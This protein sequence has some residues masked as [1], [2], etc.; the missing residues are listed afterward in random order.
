MKR[1]RGR[2]KRRKNDNDEDEEK[3]PMPSIASLVT[4]PDLPGRVSCLSCIVNELKLLWTG[5]AEDLPD[6]EVWSTSS[7]LKLYAAEHPSF[8]LARLAALSVQNTLCAV[9]LSKLEESYELALDQSSSDGDFTTELLVAIE[10]SNAVS[11]LAII[12]FVFDRCSSIDT[13]VRHASCQALLKKRKMVRRFIQFCRDDVVTETSK[14]GQRLLWCLVYVPHGREAIAGYG[15]GEALITSFLAWLKRVREAQSISQEHERDFD[16]HSNEVANRQKE[17]TMCK[18]NNEAARIQAMRGLRQAKIDFENT[19]E[20]LQS[21]LGRLE[22][23]EVH[24]NVSKESLA[25]VAK[26]QAQLEKHMLMLLA[27]LGLITAGPAY[28]MQAIMHRY[29]VVDCVVDMI[30]RC[31]VDT[32]KAGYSEMRKQALLTV[33]NFANRFPPIQNTLRNKG[34]LPIILNELN[35]PQPSNDS[36]YTVMVSNVLYKCIDGNPESGE[37]VCNLGILG[38]LCRMLHSLYHEIVHGDSEEDEDKRDD[39]DDDGKGETK[40]ENESKTDSGAE[41]KEIKL[42]KESAE[43]KAARLS[44]SEA[45]LRVLAECSRSSETRREE[46]LGENVI[47]PLL[48]LAATPNVP[49]IVYVSLKCLGNL[50]AGHKPTQDTIVTG[51][52]SGV[53]N[54]LSV[55]CSI[56]DQ[57]RAEVR[58]V[59]ETREAKDLAEPNTEDERSL[60]ENIAFEAQRCLRLVVERNDRSR[61]RAMDGVVL[62]SCCELLENRSSDAMRRDACKILSAVLGNDDRVDDANDNGNVSSPS[63]KIQKMGPAAQGTSNQDQNRHCLYDTGLPNRVCQDLLFD[64]NVFPHLIRCVAVPNRPAIEDQHEEDEESDDNE[65]DDEQ[66]E[67]DNNLTDIAPLDVAEQ[68][69]E[70]IIETCEEENQLLQKEEVADTALSTIVRENPMDVLC[71]M[72]AAAAKTVGRLVKSHTGGKDYACRIQH[73]PVSLLRLIDFAEPMQTTRV[74]ILSKRSQAGAGDA[75]VAYARRLGARWLFPEGTYPGVRIE[76]ALALAWCIQGT[77]LLGKQQALRANALQKLIMLNGAATLPERVAAS[78]ALEHL[79]HNSALAREDFRR[80]GGLLP[81]IAMLMGQPE[82]ITNAVSLITCIVINNAKNKSELARLGGVPALVRLLTHAKVEHA[83]QFS[84]VLL[85]KHIIMHPEDA[86]ILMDTYGGRALPKLVSLLHS[87]KSTLTLL[88]SC[89][90]I[91]LCSRDSERLQILLLKLGTI[92]LLV[93]MITPPLKIDDKTALF[94]LA[95]VTNCA[96]NMA[97]RKRLK[98][99]GILRAMEALGAWEGQG[100][101]VEHL[102]RAAST[103]L[104]ACTE[105]FIFDDGS[106]EFTQGLIVSDVTAGIWKPWPY[107][108][109]VQQ[110]AAKV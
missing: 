71:A 60:S 77:E 105:P 25:S 15:G 14:F 11:R 63:P 86:D 101:D 33:G 42:E 9:L 54:G 10:A 67:N 87:A 65:S 90:I 32:D 75:S 29:G 88:L 16:H 30:N 59:I 39:D 38:G 22:A 20:V 83:L 45:S 109:K 55:L 62:T 74:A 97:C 89:Q 80:L 53:G 98:R 24:Y 41:G 2:R 57:V 72:R 108:D 92:E 5:N 4:T 37:A 1:R 18:E 106:A 47:L 58:D 99:C 6:D 68:Q 91:A 48:T 70:G 96:G 50:V 13:E 7:M 27:S 84:L 23:A 49:R 64:S 12:G 3:E 21:A 69:K 95:A 19:K 102:R 17:V 107:D 46:I 100:Q 56:L 81:L 104:A 28:D 103:A 85:A 61:A 78:V 66:E 40:E 43:A 34:L 31:A 93:R 44:Q 110:G 82:E 94:C 73:T 35:R 76:A 36:T 52:E 26:V 8:E 51:D 79:C